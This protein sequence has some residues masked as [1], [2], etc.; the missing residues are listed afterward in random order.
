MIRMIG[1]LI[2]F[3]RKY[4]NLTQKELADK[5]KIANCTLSH[6]EVESRSITFEDLLK[7]AE[8][9]DFK[10]ILQN[11]KNNEQF[12]ISDFIRKDI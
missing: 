12:E 7:I 3:M 11:K 9:C 10:F 5:L 2:K 8:E 4:N 6:Y 1:K